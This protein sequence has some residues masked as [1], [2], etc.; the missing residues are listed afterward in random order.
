[1]ELP[2]GIIR[3]LY[4]TTKINISYPTILGK[5][6]NELMHSD[7][8]SEITFGELRKYV[9]KRILQDYFTNINLIAKYKLIMRY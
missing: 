5:Y 3:L 7:R 6:I 4:L 8:A 2:Y 9:F 1:M